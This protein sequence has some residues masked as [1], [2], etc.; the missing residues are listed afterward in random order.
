MS[1][2][3]IAGSVAGAPPSWRRW[4]V[5]VGPAMLVSVGYMDP[6]NW[7]SDLEG[8]SRF[9]YAL[10]WVLAVSNAIAIF[11]Q[12]LASRLGIGSGLDLAQACRT[13][14]PR[15]VVLVLWAL[16]QC[17]IVACDLAEVIGSAVA[18][19]LLFGIPI[20]W[21]AVITVFD[22]FL[23]LLL[24][25]RG[26]R[27]VEAVVIVLVATIGACLAAELWI[28]QPAWREVARGFRPALT[29]EQLYV[30]V[31][32]LG[33]TVMPHNLYLHSAL[34][35]TRR[36]ADNAEAKR[37]AMRTSLLNTVL[38]L[39]LA[40]LVNGA[41]L[42]VAA[43]VFHPKDIAV[44][45]LREAYHLL[46]PLLGTVGASALFAIALLAAGQSATIT[47]TMAGQAV[48]LGFLQ[49]ETRPL[50]VRLATRLAAVLPAVVAIAVFGEDS[51]VSLLIGTQI[52]LSMQLPFAIVPLV[53]VTSSVSAM[54]A[55]VNGIAM[56][57]VGALIAVFIT[58]VNLWLIWQ[59]LESSAWFPLIAAL[60]LAGVAL[61]VYLAAR[62]LQSRGADFA[63]APLA[64]GG[65]PE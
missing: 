25:H 61:L 37:S 58:L 11:L 40:F 15:P 55:L 36:V 51:T 62:P 9:G 3:S 30:A 13:F 57:V 7:A 16:C 60:A 8:G 17:A 44:T 54:G 31:A 49:L 21:G 27:M 35:K 29:P 5:F 14:Y 46:A 63:A 10:I 33:A 4:F 52:V 45:D 53:R 26:V 20:L 65:A 24:Q 23:I 38:A 47:G 59:A 48:M 6:G 64:L 34:V 19:N 18:L 39:N 28:A 1:P 32:I 41:I 42:I 43:D 56:R 50:T 2:Q 22:V 12:H